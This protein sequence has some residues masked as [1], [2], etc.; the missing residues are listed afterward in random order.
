MTSDFA[1]EVAKY[2][3]SILPHQEFWECASLLFHSIG[4]AAC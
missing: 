4:D 1:T 3:K 2:L